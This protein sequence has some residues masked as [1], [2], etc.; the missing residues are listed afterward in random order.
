MLV[1]TYC[2]PVPLQPYHL[3]CACY[4]EVRVA[5]GLIAVIFLSVFVFCLILIGP[6]TLLPIA[7]NYWCN[8]ITYIIAVKQLTQSFKALGTVN[9][10]FCLFRFISKTLLSIFEYHF[11]Q[12]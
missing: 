11:M 12:I 4:C 10:Y 3:H 9:R 5:V 8:H 7:V 6:K 1:T 2:R